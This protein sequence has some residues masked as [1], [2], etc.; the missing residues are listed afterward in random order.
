[1][2]NDKVLKIIQDATFS[3]GVGLELFAQAQNLFLFAKDAL[4]GKAITQEDIDKSAELRKVSGK[5]LDDL[6]A[7]KANKPT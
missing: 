4:N 6:L 1:M 5:I 2:D 7:K 3:M